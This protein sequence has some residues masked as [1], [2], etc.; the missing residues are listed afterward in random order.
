MTCIQAKF[1]IDYPAFSFLIDL[2]FPATGITV[3]FGPSGSGKT[4]CLRAIA[5]L[6]ALEHSYLSVAGDVWQSSE[7]GIFIP[8]H[9]RDIGYVFQEAR[10]VSASV[11]PA[12]S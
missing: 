3:L 7:Q 2:E 9:Q 1:A 5:G 4:T 10:V 11:R 6:Q 8:T 12:Q